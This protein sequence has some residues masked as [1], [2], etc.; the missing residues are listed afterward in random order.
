VETSGPVRGRLYSFTS[1]PLT[2]ALTWI[3]DV[4]GWDERLGRLKRQVEG[5]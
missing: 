4:G 5:R 3:A 2:D 1:E